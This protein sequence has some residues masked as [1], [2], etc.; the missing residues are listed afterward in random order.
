MKGLLV[1]VLWALA[2]S[3]VGGLIERV[4]G[5]GLT[6]PVMAAFAVAGI[7][8]AARIARATRPA[9]VTHIHRAADPGERIA[10]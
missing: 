7:Y 6:V 8:L 3:Y 10:A 4:T 9:T 5:L 1:I 2:G